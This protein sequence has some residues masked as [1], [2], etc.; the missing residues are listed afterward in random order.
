MIDAY[1]TLFCCLVF[2]VAGY[3]WHHPRS[4]AHR[5]RWTCHVADIRI[6][7]DTVLVSPTVSDYQFIQKCILAPKPYDASSCN[8]ISS[9]SWKMLFYDILWYFMIFYDILWLFPWCS[10][11]VSMAHQTSLGSSRIH[12][13][14][15]RGGTME[16]AIQYRCTR[17]CG[18][19]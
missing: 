17:R 9:F 10:H 11:D 14:P 7:M 13:S 6:L 15:R 18:D 19:H 4:Y 1:Q 8:I 2:L 12:S 16:C 5:C 3:K